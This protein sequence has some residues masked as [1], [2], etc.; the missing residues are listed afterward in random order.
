MEAKTAMTAQSE[1]EQSEQREEKQGQRIGYVRVS[2]VDQNTER[3]LAGE[4][5]DMVFT[6]KASGKSIE[7][8]PQLQA[9]LKH[10]RRGDE[11][12]VH[13]FDRLARNLRELNALVEDLTSRGVTVTFVKNNMTFDG[14]KKDGTA[15]K[16]S[17]AML[18]LSIMGAVAEFERDMIQERQREGIAIAKAAGKY[19]GGKVKL[20]S[21]RAAELRKRVAAGEKVAG[22]AREF[23]VSRQTVYN[24]VSQ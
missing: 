23:K 16:N 9:L 6:D 7:G 14:L 20:S 15:K 19:R 3:Q 5:L 17:H 2:T 21:D 10:V 8:R 22:L 11:V 18:M 4:T 13:S 24:T 1:V 12:V